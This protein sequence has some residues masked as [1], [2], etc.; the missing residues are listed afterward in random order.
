[1]RDGI[2]ADLAARGVGG[3]LARMSRE[4]RAEV[5]RIATRF[6]ITLKHAREVARFSQQLFA[7]LQ[8]LHQLPLAYGRLLEAA[9]YLSETGH[10]INDAAHHKH[11]HYIVAN[12]DISGFTDRERA[13][14]AA[15]CRYHRKAM[16]QA[17][18]AEFQ[19]L[20]PEEKRALPLMIPVLRLA[21]NLDRGRH[22]DVELVDSEIQDTRVTLRLRSPRPLDLAEWAASRVSEVFQQVYGRGVMITR[23]R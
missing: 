12:V 3:E 17:S 13:F 9:C 20:P 22:L 5:E 1:V 18:H 2:V 23:E 15:L 4:Q 19:A 6:G 14:I 21:F 7:R 16:P 8:P 11:A 10:S